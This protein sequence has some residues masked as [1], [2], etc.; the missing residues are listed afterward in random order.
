MSTKKYKP[1][2]IVHLVRQIEVE[3]ANGKTTPKA[4]RDAQHVLV[5]CV[6]I[7]QYIGHPRILQHKRPRVV[8][9]PV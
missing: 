8:P 7:R 6:D 5:V 4:C 1:G 9:C 2:Q 3:I